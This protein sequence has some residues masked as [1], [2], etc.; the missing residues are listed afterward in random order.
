MNSSVLTMMSAPPGRSAR[1]ALSAAGFIATSTFGR[2]ARGEDV[3]VGEVHL[4]AGDTGQGAGGRADLGREVRQG[5]DVVAELG[6]LGGEPVAGEL[7]AV[8]GVSGE[9]D[10]HPIQ[11]SDLLGHGRGLLGAGKAVTP[12]SWRSPVARQLCA[13]LLC[14]HPKRTSVWYGHCRGHD[15]HPVNGTERGQR[16]PIQR[17]GKLVGGSMD[18]R[19]G[20][21]YERVCCTSPRVAGRCLLEQRVHVAVTWSGAGELTASKPRTPAPGAA[22]GSVTATVASR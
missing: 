14:L 10:D 16:T 20:H 7:H 18:E 1:L 5:R 11:L 17:P 4:E 8:A 19:D 3:E 15:S 6:G 21:W 22:S 12:R 13:D 9:T 2:V